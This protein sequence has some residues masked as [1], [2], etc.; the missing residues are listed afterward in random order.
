LIGSRISP[1]TGI[2]WLLTEHVTGLRLFEVGE[3]ATWTRVAHWLGELHTR[4]AAWSRQAV[5]RRPRLLQYDREWYSVWLERAL[6]FCPADG[7]VDSRRSRAA[8]E[9][10]AARY[11]KVV[12]RLLSLPQTLIHGEFYPSNVLVAGTPTDSVPCPLDWEMTAIGPAVIDLAALTSG[13]WQP[14]DRRAAIAAYVEG[15]GSSGDAFGEAAESVEYAYLHLA[16][17]WCG[18][19]GRRRAPAGHVRDWLADAVDR[20][21]A[22]RL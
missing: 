19:F 9:W 13:Q 22:M 1:A 5:N 4:L 14:D 21:E 3:P 15:S 17:Q 16:V 6:R 18:W 2:Y 20:A 11:H 8:L 7:A 12:E 10:L